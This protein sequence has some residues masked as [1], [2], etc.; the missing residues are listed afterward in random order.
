MAQLNHNRLAE[1]VAEETDP[2]RRSFR[3]AMHLILRAIATSKALS[4]FMIM[5][6]GILLAIRYHSSRFTRDVDFSTSTPIQQVDVPLLL[7]NIEIS[8][9][10]VSAEN[11]YGLALALQSHKINPSNQPEVSFPTLQLK[12]AYAKRSAPREMKKFQLKQAPHIIQIDYSFNE[13]V[14]ETESQPV[15]GGILNMYAYH[16]LIAEKLRSTLQQPIRERARFQDIYDL[17]LLVNG[18]TPTTDDK[19]KILDKLHS[20]SLDRDVPLHKLGMR[21]PEVIEYSQHEYSTIAPLI[22]DP[23]KFGTAYR[24]VREFYESLPWSRPEGL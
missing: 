3:Q 13:W 21:Q 19:Q 22:N 12:I 20:A 4:P 5:K 17:F 9:L 7:K 8:L 1:W 23:P 14:S 6:G 15:D 16:D 10:P 2:D 18:T 11:E 24:V